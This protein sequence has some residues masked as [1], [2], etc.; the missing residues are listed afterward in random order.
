[1]LEHIRALARRHVEYGV[2]ETHYAK[3]GEALLWTL[4]QGLGESFTG[5][6]REAWASAYGLLSRTM[7]EAANG[8]MRK[9]A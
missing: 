8:T 7:I 1:M 9:A 3:V 6:V 2:E 4:E 5:E